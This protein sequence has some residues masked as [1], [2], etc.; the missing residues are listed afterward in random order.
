MHKNCL[1][2]FLVISGQILFGQNYKSIRG[3]SGNPFIPG[4]YA[5]PT[6]VCYHNKFYIYATI[7]PWGADS[8]ALWESDDFQN[9]HYKKLNWPT[10]LLCSSPESSGSMAWAP[11]V[12]KGKDNRFHMFVSVGSEI[13]AG[14]SNSPE[15]P[16]KNVK[17]DNSPFVKTQ[18]KI[19]VTALE[20]AFGK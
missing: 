1:V 2:V 7:D 4:Y 16:W 17:A 18:K 12:I 14:V 3:L 11:G 8:L 9:W 5:D 13:Y 6:I 20:E 10:K 19:N 15:G